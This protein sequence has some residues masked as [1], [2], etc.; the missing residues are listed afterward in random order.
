M[1]KNY[2]SPFKAVKHLDKIEKLRKGELI[3]PTFVQWDLTNP[4]PM[5]A[6]YG[7]CTDVMEHIPTEDVFRVI[8]NIMESAHKVFFQI[9]TIDDS[10]GELIEQPLHL[11]VKPHSWWENLFCA[12][13]YKV[14]WEAELDNSA[15]FYV[16]NP[17]R[18]ETC[19]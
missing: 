8:T 1:N 5:E 6:D 10:M 19:Q 17:D 14:D 13:G 9:S 4:I 7:I 15:L 12:R 11:T 18:R 2:Y 16:S 3:P